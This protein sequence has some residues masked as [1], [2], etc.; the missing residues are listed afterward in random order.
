MPIHCHFVGYRNFRRSLH[1]AAEET[2][3]IQT[4]QMVHLPR[5]APRRGRRTAE[6]SRNSRW[7]RSFASAASQIPA[8]ANAP[9]WWLF[10]HEAIALKGVAARAHRDNSPDFPSECLGREKQRFSMARAALAGAWACHRSCR[11]PLGA[12]WDFSARSSAGSVTRLSSTALH[13]SVCRVRMLVLSQLT[14]LNRS[15]VHRSSRAQVLTISRSR[16]VECG[17]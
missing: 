13:T 5:P 9:L 8:V 15:G 17:R 16:A 10:R 7:Q 6:E 2:S 12:G 3:L 4:D 11:A 14:N 1:H